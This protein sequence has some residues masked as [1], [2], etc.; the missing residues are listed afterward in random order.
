MAVLPCPDHFP[1]GTPPNCMRSNPDVQRLRTLTL[2][3]DHPTISTRRP[4][5]HPDPSSNFPNEVTSL[6]SRHRPG[7]RRK[8]RKKRP[9]GPSK[10][11][12]CA[13]LLFLVNLTLFISPLPF[14]LFF[15]TSCSTHITAIV[16]SLYG[17]RRGLHPSHLFFFAR[18]LS[19][20]STRLYFRSRGSL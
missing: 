20:S 2:N 18:E 16:P 15:I 4:Q 11:G 7:K 10:P 13:L 9:N 19:L 1:S 17:P 3:P 5:I 6:S 12:S 14:S 8:E